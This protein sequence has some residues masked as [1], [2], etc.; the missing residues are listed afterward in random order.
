MLFFLQACTKLDL[1]YQNIDDEKLKPLANLLK[2][3][4]VRQFIFLFITYLPFA[5]NIDTYSAE[6]LG[7][8]N[9]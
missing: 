4:T 8:Q 1:E 9:R 6:S 7:E 3:N 2:T 5:F